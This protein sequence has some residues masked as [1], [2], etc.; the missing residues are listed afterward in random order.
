MIL[1]H[2]WIFD[3]PG[4]VNGWRYIKETANQVWGIFVGD[5]EADYDPQIYINKAK[6]ADRKRTRSPKKCSQQE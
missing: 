4:I 3:N 6:R 1:C 5:K 2:S